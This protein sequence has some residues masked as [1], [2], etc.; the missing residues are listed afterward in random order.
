MKVVPV[1]ERTPVLRLAESIDPDQ[2]QD[3]VLGAL[4][5]WATNIVRLPLT[6]DAYADL[7]QQTCS[8]PSEFL[9]F[10]EHVGKL[11]LTDSTS[12]LDRA[13]EL[14]RID[15]EY[16]LADGRQNESMGAVQSLLPALR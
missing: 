11:T 13:L 16:V 8:F 10:V 1:A 7:R 5:R 14:E 12:G 2:Y 9:L 6:P 15:D 4:M 3:S